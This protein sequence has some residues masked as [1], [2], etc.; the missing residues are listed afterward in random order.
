MELHLLSRRSD[1]RAW[2]HLRARIDAG[3]MVEIVLLHEAVMETEVTVGA[4]LGGLDPSKLVVM[5]S[6]EAA[7][8]RRVAERWALIDYSGIID[9]CVKAE[10]VTSW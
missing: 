1:L 4:A 3:A 5:A 8:R 7:T 10:K 9:R 2:E 6:S